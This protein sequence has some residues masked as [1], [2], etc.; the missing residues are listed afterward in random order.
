MPPSGQ[1]KEV[2]GLDVC[3]LTHL[4]HVTPGSCTGVDVVVVWMW[5]F[6]GVLALIC[7]LH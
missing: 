4:F 5:M 2:P 1:L 6:L 7:G 3:R